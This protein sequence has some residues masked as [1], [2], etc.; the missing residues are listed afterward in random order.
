MWTVSFQLDLSANEWESQKVSILIKFHFSPRVFWKRKIKSSWRISFL[1]CPIKYGFCARSIG[2]SKSLNINFH[3]IV[4]KNESN[5]NFDEN[6]FYWRTVEVFRKLCC[7]IANARL[8]S[9][10]N[11]KLRTWNALFVRTRRVSRLLAHISSKI[12]TKFS[13]VRGN[14]NEKTAVL[15]EKIK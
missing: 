14:L 8:F 7:A 15:E 6:I 4:T 12:R 13:I 1:R 2:L 3:Q 11:V 10:R 5:I 9:D